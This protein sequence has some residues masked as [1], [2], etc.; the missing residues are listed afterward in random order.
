MV[1]AVKNECVFL[2]CGARRE[3]LEFRVCLMAKSG[4]FKNT[5]QEN[6]M[7]RFLVQ[8]DSSSGS[9][10]AARKCSRREER[11]VRSLGGGGKV[12]KGVPKPG[13]SRNILPAPPCCIS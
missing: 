8:R 4:P 10:E 11:L 7:V 9:V 5:N 12:G 6:D 13:I 3:G 2:G 1:Q